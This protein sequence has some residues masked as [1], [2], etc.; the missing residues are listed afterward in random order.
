MS[1]NDLILELPNQLT[2]AGGEMLAAVASAGAQVRTSMNELESGHIDTIA[3][4][5]KPRA[6]VVMGAGGSS[7]PGDILAACAG[8]GGNVPIIT[9][10]GPQLPGWVG[11]LDLVVGVS[12]SGRS[13]ETLA[14]LAE[15]GRRRAQ[16]VGIGP[17]GS[18]L[19]E[20][21]ASM[22]GVFM[23]LKPGHGGVR[24]RALTW[25]LTVPLLA[26]ADALDIIDVSEKQLH[27]A[28][29]E[30]DQLSISCGPQVELG[31]NPA[32]DLAL[33]GAENLMLLWGTPGVPTA[34]ARRG[35]RQFAENAGIPATLGAFPEV[36]RTHVRILTGHWGGDSEFDL[37][38][39][40]IADPGTTPKPVAVFLSDEAADPL[41]SQLVVTCTH[42]A[43][44]SGVRV[45]PLSGG[46]GPAL[47]RYARLSQPLDLASVYAATMIDV[48]PMAAAADLDPVLGSG[49]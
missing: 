31:D 42:I 10:G 26:I 5:G 34:A 32:K 21:T 41:S 45:Y 7:A 4:W 49:S 2:Q 27:D 43:E 35:V 12:A 6:I 25:R 48:D 33:L 38:R 3:S 19:A 36:A 17:A 23:P 40:R 15:A 8:P 46:Q 18:Q 44:N 16:V 14:V 24:A 1:V 28:A 47:L 39:D 22:R 11:A 9:T 37:F 20:L 13:P 30:L 29:D